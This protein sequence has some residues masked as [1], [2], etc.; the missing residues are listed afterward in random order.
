MEAPAPLT[1][2]SYNFFLERG[3]I[4]VTIVDIVGSLLSRWLNFDYGWI[5]IPSMLVYI[6]LAYLIGSIQNL[7]TALWS[8]VKLSLYDGTVG[9]TLSLLL[10]ANIGGFEKKIYQYG[11]IG[12]MFILV[13]DVIFSMILGLIGYSIAKSKKRIKTN[14]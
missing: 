13:L 1:G 9:F 2:K 7:K 4:A 11:L 12:W 5:S 14:R 10:E 8:I 6:G 3:I